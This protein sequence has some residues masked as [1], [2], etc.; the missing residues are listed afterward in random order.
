M[1]GLCTCSKIVTRDFASKI[2]NLCNNCGKHFRAT[3]SNSDNS[4][5]FDENLYMNTEKFGDENIIYENINDNLLDNDKDIR[6]ICSC[7]EYRGEGKFCANCGGLQFFENP[8][9]IF[10]S[11]FKD[12][13]NFI[14]G[15]IENRPITKLRR[16]YSF[17]DI[18]HDD[19][20]T[21][22]PFSSSGKH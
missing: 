13:N 18:A 16:S 11:N 22:I 7:E 12:D 6:N 2:R 15:S 17:A 14:F 5:E 19:L 10:L 1:P 8:T 20:Y 21:Q 4:E 9:S 3:D